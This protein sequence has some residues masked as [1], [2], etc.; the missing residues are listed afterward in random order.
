MAFIICFELQAQITKNKL[1]LHAQKRVVKNR[2]LQERSLS[3]F[4]PHTMCGP[5]SFPLCIQRSQ[6]LRTL[7]Y[8]SHNST[9]TLC[10]K[11]KRRSTTTEWR[12]AT[13]A[14]THLHTQSC[15]RHFSEKRQ[16]LL[17][18]P[19]P[20]KRVDSGIEAHSICVQ[21]LAPFFDLACSQLREQVKSG[22]PLRH[23][24]AA[25]DHY[26]QNARKQ[27][28]VKKRYYADQLTKTKLCVQMCPKL[29]CFQTKSVS[30][31]FRS[32][33]NPAS[34]VEEHEYDSFGGVGNRTQYSTAAL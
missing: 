16:G 14:A 9:R 23:L 6:Q 12:N 3:D 2:V 29:D 22:F 10:R 27:N 32:S 15:F 4:D 25:A 8:K 24:G 11:T 33:T 1:E 5:C 26:G 7:L 13:A 20:S 17:P 18:L 34:Q 28:S 19:T 30:E 31:F 21:R